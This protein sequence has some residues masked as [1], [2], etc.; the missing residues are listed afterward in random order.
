MSLP[1]LVSQCLPVHHGGAHGVTR[2]TSPRQNH[3]GLSR[4]AARGQLL[5][6]LAD[7]D[8]S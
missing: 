1:S 4:R 6:K 3:Y 2:P 7:S 8:N 5:A